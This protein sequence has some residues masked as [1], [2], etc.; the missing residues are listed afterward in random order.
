MGNYEFMNLD[1]ATSTLRR[2]FRYLFIER[3]D[4][5]IPEHVARERIMFNMMKHTWD[6]ASGWHARLAEEIIEFRIGQSTTLGW[7]D[8]AADERHIQGFIRSQR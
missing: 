1:I 8:W 2:E 3:S 5:V 7:D 4:G 6:P